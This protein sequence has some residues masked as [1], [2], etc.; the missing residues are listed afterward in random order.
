MSPHSDLLAVIGVAP[1][2]PWQALSGQG[3]PEHSKFGPKPLIVKG[4]RAEGTVFL[5]ARASAAQQSICLER[6]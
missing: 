5:S 6:R 4:F 1:A 2:A 3:Q